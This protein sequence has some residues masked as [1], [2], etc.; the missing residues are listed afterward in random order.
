MTERAVERSPQI[1]ARIAGVLYLIIIAGGM[2]AEAV[3]EQAVVSGDAAATARNI[4]AHEL[5]YRLGFA[6]GVVVCACNIPL[7]LIFYDLF[8]LVNRSLSLL[9][10][11]FILV[12]TSIESVNLLNHFAPLILLGGRRYLNVFTAEQLQALAYVSLR[13]Q[14]AG[15]NISLAVFGFFCLVTGHLIFWSTFLPRILGVLLAIAGL[16]YLTN[17]FAD[18]LFPAFSAHLFPYIL[19]P[20]F[21]AE[22]SLCLW[23]LVMGVNVPKWKEKAQDA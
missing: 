21:V 1:Y 12:S 16:C 23:L 13:L 22:L 9:A 3:R 7:A 8:K 14:S 19:V 17:S 11:F 6:A 15:Y 20:S 5:V 4:L 2:F 10:V 18:F